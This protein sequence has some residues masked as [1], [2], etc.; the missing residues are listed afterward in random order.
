MTETTR[1]ERVLVDSLHVGSAAF[2]DLELPR[3][4]E[5]HIG[6]AGMLGLDAL[7][8]QR[9]M[10]DFERRRITI[11]DA[12]R[13]A[14][15]LDGEIVV[16]ARLQRGQLILTQVKAAGRSLDAVVDTGS[17]ITIGNMALRD[18]IVR[19]GRGNLQTLEM[20]GVTG[21]PVMIEVA[22]IERLQVGSITFSR[23]PIAFADLP[24]FTAFGLKDRPALL[25]GTDLMENFRKVSLDF[26]SRRVRFQLRRCDGIAI[27]MTTT[28]EGARLSADSSNPSVCSG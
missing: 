17:E 6:A 26:K 19:R 23:V 18:Q 20:F 25:L 15:R 2:R 4:E 11:G 5:R 16:T 9:M 8:D 21:K 22:T 24:P 13:P 3:L 14:P 1:V 28:G 12:S 7:V 27:R 10:L